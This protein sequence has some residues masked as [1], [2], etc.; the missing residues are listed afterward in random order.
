M[1]KPKLLTIAV[2]LAFASLQAHAIGRLADVIVVTHD[3]DATLPL[4][5][6]RIDYWV[7]GNPW[8]LAG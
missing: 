8:C 1:L 4:H 7:A 6:Y 5:Y 3:S 2:V